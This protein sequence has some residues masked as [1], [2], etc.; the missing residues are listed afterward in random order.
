MLWQKMR[1]LIQRHCHVCVAKSFCNHKDVHSTFNTSC[2]EC[3][4]ECNGIEIS[5]NRLGTPSWEMRSTN[6]RFVSYQGAVPIN[7]ITDLD[8]NVELFKREYPALLKA[9]LDSMIKAYPE[10]RRFKEDLRMF[11]RLF[12]RK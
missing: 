6:S 4:S 3:M 1:V 8:N 2:C 5:Y 7:N 10:D 12:G 11:L 9:E